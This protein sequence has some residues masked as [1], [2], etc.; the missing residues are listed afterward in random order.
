MKQERYD[1]STPRSFEEI[2]NRARKKKKLTSLYFS[3][4]KIKLTLGKF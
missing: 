4:I 3:E 1:E 2:A